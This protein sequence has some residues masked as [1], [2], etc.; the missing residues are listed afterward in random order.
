[1]W[2]ILRGGKIG[3]TLEE[4]FDGFGLIVYVSETPKTWATFDGVDV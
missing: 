3:A 2:D 1:L 4:K